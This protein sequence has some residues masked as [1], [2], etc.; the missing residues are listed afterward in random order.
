MNK[1]I[2]L[3]QILWIDGVAALLAGVLVLLFSSW[4]SALFNLP[5]N[6]LRAQAITTLIYASYSL[7]LARQKT[8]PKQLIYLLA[9][10]NFGYAFFVIGLVFYYFRTATI[11]G[12][13][14][15]IAEAL[16]IGVLAFFEW[17]RIK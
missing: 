16:F 14:Y 10:A 3:Q 17:S 13:I 15:L 6:L 9:I 2:S 11:Y 1:K 5:E 8:H 4:L 12:L 7:S